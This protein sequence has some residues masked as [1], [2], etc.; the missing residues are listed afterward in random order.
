MKIYFFYLN[1]FL[2][3]VEKTTTHIQVFIGARK[4]E[5]SQFGLH[6][7]DVSSNGDL[8]SS[9]LPDRLSSNIGHDV[10][11]TSKVFIAQG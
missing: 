7:Q 2:E 5:L 1:G 9:F 4:N 11:F 3:I 6:Y 8:Y 10:A